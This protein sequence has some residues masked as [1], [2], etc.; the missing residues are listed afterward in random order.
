MSPSLEA[1]ESIYI[2]AQ[3]SLNDMLAACPSQTEHDQIMTEYV[4][5]RQNYFACI[6][7]TFHDDDPV[8]VTLVTQARAS[9]KE[10]EHIDKQLG[11]IAKV[12]A[13]MTTA[14]KYGSQIVAKIVTL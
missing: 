2:N 9:A 13:I 12:I 10:L 6:N 3:L 5:A 8:L 11:D 4:C 1:V 7:K 14:V